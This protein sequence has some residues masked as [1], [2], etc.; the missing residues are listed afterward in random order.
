MNVMPPPAHPSDDVSRFV[1]AARDALTDQMIE[2]VAVTGSNALEILD[3]LDDEDTNAAVH[4]LIDRLAEMHK[5]GALDTVCDMVL[6]LHGMRSAVTDSI[7]ERLFTLIENILNTVANDDVC[8]LV[9]VANH[10]LNE[11]AAESAK[12]PAGG[13]IRATVAL[14]TKPETQ[15]SLQFLLNFAHKLQTHTSNC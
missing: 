2:R 15:R 11:A 5:I 1:Q 14:L 13:G 8:D 7:V 12:M 10:A 9:D 6:L 3:R 4:H